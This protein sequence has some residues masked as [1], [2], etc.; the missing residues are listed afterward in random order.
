MNRSLNI[1]RRLIEFLVFCVVL[2]FA[3]AGAVFAQCKPAGTEFQVNTYTENSQI[4]PSVAALSGGGFTV[5]WVSDGQD[6]SSFGVY[7]QMFD[8]AGRKVGHEIRVNTY[9]TDEQSGPS[10]AAVAGGGFVVTWNSRGQD[11]SGL[12]V[13]GQVFDDA[14]RKVGKEFK[15]NTYTTGGQISPSVAAVSGGGFVVTWYSQGQDGNGTG[16]YGQRFSCRPT[17]LVPRRPTVTP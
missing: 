15:V 17:V 5:T 3:F 11:G 16:V 4:T 10:V 8:N 9:T 1:T 13:Y 2:Q 14:G 7:G 6:G 12:G